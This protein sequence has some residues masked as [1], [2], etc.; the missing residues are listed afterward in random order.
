MFVDAMT[1]RTSVACWSY[2]HGSQS[3]TSLV[4]ESEIIRY[5]NV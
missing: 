3:V 4:V 2:A 1:Q 5:A